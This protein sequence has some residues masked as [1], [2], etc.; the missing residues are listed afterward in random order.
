MDKLTITLDDVP[1]EQ[2]T[3]PEVFIIECLSLKDWR[4][5]KRD[6]FDL[7]MQLLLSGRRPRYVQA[8]CENDLKAAL[9]MFRQ[10]KCRFLHFSFH[11][12]LDS[13]SLG[14]GLCNYASFADAI[15][16]FLNS[17]RVF[18]SACECGNHELFRRIYKTNPVTHSI[19][20]HSD[21]VAFDKAVAFWIAFY[22]TLY[23]RIMKSATSM[24]AVEIS[25]P[26]TTKNITDIAG[27]LSLVVNA[28]LCCCY[29]DAKNQK[30]VMKRLEK[31]NDCFRWVLM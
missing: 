2:L 19:L 18:I 22:Y 30:V 21:K 26:L 17:R 3:L 25:K 31:N 6:G 16:G 27:R 20:A 10:S 28:N 9:I 4:D 11:G 23:Q 7:Y 14:D 12:S 13:I 5:G 29:F 8:M 1:D 15:R 24:D